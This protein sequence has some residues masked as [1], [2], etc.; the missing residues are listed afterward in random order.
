[1][2]IKSAGLIFIML[3]FSQPYVGLAQSP[4]SCSYQPDGSIVCTTGGGNDGN[5]SE[6]G[7]GNSRNGGEDPNPEL[8]TCSPGATRLVTVYQPEPTLGNNQC[9]IWENLVADCTGETLFGSNQGTTACPQVIQQPHHPCT[10][11][12]MSGGGITCANSEW[13]LRAR[14]TFPEIYLDVRPYPATLVRWPTAIRNGGLTESSGSGRVSYVS[15]GGGSSRN[16]QEGDWKGL[17]L[18]LTLKH[19]G[20]LSVSLPHIG[21]LFLVNSG[22]PTIIKW[23]IPSHPVA[24]G[25]PLAGTIYGLEELPGDIPVFVGHG[26]APYRLFWDLGYDAYEA[27]TGCVPGPD[28]NGNYDCRRKTGHTEIVGYEWRRHAS[29]GEISPEDVKDL[30]PSLKA[31]LNGDRTLDA[32]WNSNLTLRR[33][34]DA[35]NVNN[36]TYQRSWNWGGIIYWAVREGQGQIGWP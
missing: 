23:E 19:A 9:S 34:D 31:D 36:P 2:R 33:M 17:R 15:N 35:G 22:S 1:M 14:V 13:K 29:S 11:F 4:P 16:P 30:P 24:G 8:T 6:G 7:N 32:Y 18:T 26:R 25:G 10:T 28:D 21:D 20:L 12:A 5:G 27:V 3:W